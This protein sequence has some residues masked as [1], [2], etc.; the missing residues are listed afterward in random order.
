MT[1]KAPVVDDDPDILDAVSDILTSL[2]HECDHANSVES[3]RQ[4]LECNEYTY[5]L[6]DLEIPVRAGKSFAR[7]Q[8]GE[9]LLEE[10]VQRTGTRRKPVIIVM[11][12]H[13]TDGPEL[14][15]D[16]MKKG[17]VDYVTKPF[18]NVGKTLDNSIRE[19]LAGMGKDFFS[20]CQP[21][22][23]VQHQNAEI[24]PASVPKAFSGGAM[25]FYADR[26]ELCGATICGGP[27]CEQAR[28]TL[29][30]LCRKN[31]KG[32]FAG[33]G[34]QKLAEKIDRKGGASSVPGLIRDLR[35]RIVEAL[36]QTNIECQREDVI[37][38]T[39]RG[40][41]F[42]DWISIQD[43]ESVESSPMLQGHENTDSPGDGPVNVPLNDPVDSNDV[44]PVSESVDPA[45]ARQEW[46]LEQVT[47]G[48]KLRAPGFAAELGCSDRTVKRDLG[49]L[50]PKIEFVGSPR[51]GYYQL[52]QRR[53]PR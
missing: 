19:A 10:I 40:Y 1:P 4:C 21:A 6:L 27:R 20:A 33:F 38:Q 24:E 7:I 26:V 32:G 9:N 46:I 34:G 22:T 37:Q 13:G 39:N 5:V 23:V 45:V 18:K 15:V 17:A 42:R 16:V 52:R 28:K 51:T 47:K 49:I 31:Q 30:L 35:T 36:R 12:A 41:H 43:R 29:D 50:E 14:A 3:A 48:R 44:G 8:N 2:G 11:T 25:V 53:K